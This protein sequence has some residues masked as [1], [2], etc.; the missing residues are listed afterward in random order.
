MREQFEKIGQ[1]GL[2]NPSFEHDNCGIGA[3]VDIKGRPSHKLV[4]DALHI[5][6]NLEHRERC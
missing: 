3:V 5:V 6:E 4:S 1:Q 2:Y